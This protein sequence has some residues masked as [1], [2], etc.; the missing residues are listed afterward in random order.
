MQISI[1]ITLRLCLVR[2]KAFPK[3]IPFSENAIFRKGKY[4]YVFG[5]ISKNF[6]KNIFWCLE[7]A[8]RKKTKLEKQTQ[9]P[10][11]RSRST[12]FDSALQSDDRAV[13]RDLA[14]HRVAS[15]DRDRWRDLTKRRSRSREAPC[16]LRSARRRVRDLR[17]RST[18]LVLANNAD[19]SLDVRTAPTG[20]LS[21]S[22]ALV[23]SLSLSLEFIWSENRN[24]NSF[25]YSRPFFLGQQKSISGKFY[26]PNQPNTR[27]SGKAFPEMIFTQNKHSLSLIIKNYHKQQ[28]S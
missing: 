14:K 21:P 8:T 1:I 16:R 27:I 18:A 19:W 10:D 2:V 5:C 4:F 26:F 15:R 7:N 12:G 13:D 3:N 11:W 23:L 6:P 17:S 20:S 24:G 28:M 9:H 25:P 22:R